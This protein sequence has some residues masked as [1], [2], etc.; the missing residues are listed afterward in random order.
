[1]DD[2]KNCIN[3]IDLKYLKTIN[4]E[5]ILHDQ[6][7]NNWGINHIIITSDGSIQNKAIM[8]NSSNNSNAIPPSFTLNPN[9]EYNFYLFDRDSFLFVRNPAVIER[10]FIKFEQKL[11]L[12]LFILRLAY[13][14]DF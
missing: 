1:M 3:E 13:C 10:S 8:E 12:L 14:E 6:H 2:F 7:I 4:I 5:S 9:Y 11:H